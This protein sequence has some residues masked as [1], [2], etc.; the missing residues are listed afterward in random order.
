MPLAS[1]YDPSQDMSVAEPQAPQGLASYYDPTE[2]VAA[3]PGGLPDQG[4]YPPPPPPMPAYIPPAGRPGGIAGMG[5]P[6]GSTVADAAPAG[7]NPPPPVAPPAA[8]PVSYEPP[9]AAPMPMPA[10]RMS[11]AP[12]PSAAPRGAGGGGGAPAIPK[13]WQAVADAS[14]AGRDAQAAALDQGVQNRAAMAQAYRDDA[15]RQAVAAKELQDADLH[16]QSIAKA[17]GDRLDELTKSASDEKVDPNSLGND[18]GTGTTIMAIL[19][20]A[21][22]GFSAGLSGGP[23]TFLAMLDKMQDREIDAQKASIAN[24]WRGVDSANT[25]YGRLQSQ[26]GDEHLADLAYRSAQNEA[27]ATKLKG[28]IADSDSKEYQKNGSVMLAG[29]DEKSAQIRAQFQERAIAVAQ[30]AQAAQRAQA[31]QAEKAA[32]AAF[33]DLAKTGKYTPEEAARITGYAHGGAPAGAIHGIIPGDPERSEKLA[34]LGYTGPDGKTYLAAD[35]PGRAK[36]GDAI[37]AH[38]SLVKANNA[39]DALLKQPWSPSRQ[40]RLMELRTPYIAAIAQGMNSG[41]VGESEAKRYQGMVGDPDAWIHF[42]QADNAARDQLQRIA[43]D[44]LDGIITAH[45]RAGTPRPP[46]ADVMSSVP[47]IRRQ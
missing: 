3:G 42:T 16:R 33:I 25:A 37:A 7:I 31:A 27:A 18:W 5:L 13:R 9:D 19:G 20:A 38:E 34:A 35:P 30:A 1:Y 26:L 22:S 2:Y 40:A 39:V 11:P 17:A 23:N 21:L 46:Q 24:K 36:I 8:A 10:A 4:A 44:G 6:E 12:M 47:G 43:R 14:Q 45:G 29:L 28:L 41:T 32:Q 15:D